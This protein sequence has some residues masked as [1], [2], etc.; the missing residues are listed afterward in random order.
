MHLNAFPLQVFFA[1]EE[2][3]LGNNVGEEHQQ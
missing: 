3:V 2:F 1:G